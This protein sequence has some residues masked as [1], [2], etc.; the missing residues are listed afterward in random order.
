MAALPFA[1][2]SIIPLGAQDTR[3]EDEMIDFARLRQSMVD[4]QIRP[5][6]VTDPRI[7]AAMLELP[8]ERFVPAVR[9]DL[10]YLDDDIVV[11][12]AQ[13]GRPARYLMEP[14]ILARLIQALEICPE[15]SVLD[16][17]C[18]TGYSTA[19]LAR[20]AGSVTGLEQDAE[21]ARVARDRLG[22]FGA[23]NARIVQGPLTGGV[24]GGATF[25]AILLNGSVEG[26]PEALVG[27]LTEDGR[28]V[29]VIRA[30]PP[31]RATL[32][33]RSGRS[34]SR[35]PLFDAAVPALPGFDV[36]RGF[37]F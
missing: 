19:L 28:L 29:A 3:A 4:S 23:D 34:V 5:N 30:A 31:G 13:S 10:A 18:A 16:V 27:Q 8:R 21:L 14:M 35:R 26:I 11:R 15:E 7:I 6:D 20:V 24:P 37:V 32:H 12:E 33:I 17:G 2:G 25:D 1:T 36:P 22:E 9:A